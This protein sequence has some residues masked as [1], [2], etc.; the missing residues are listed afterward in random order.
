[1]VT[2][3][4]SKRSGTFK[5]GITGNVCSGKSVVRHALQR[6]GVNTMDAGESAMELLA[7]NPHKFALRLT[8]HFGSD[9]LDARGRLSRKKLTAV[10]LADPAKRELFHE[11]LNP[12]IRQEIKHFLYSQ[13][14]T[15]LRAVEASMLFETDTQHLYD[16]IWVV[17]AT[18]DKQLER[19]MNRDHVSHAHARLIVDSQWSQERK[20]TLGDRV[21]DNT[22]EIQHTETQVRK[23]LDEIKYKF[24]VGI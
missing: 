6:L 14:G 9:V 13:F 23:A 18:P 7:R 15:L 11:K 10:L 20:T 2:K 5:I 12:A 16:E 21:I 3:S 24:K 19:L 22:G 8:E 1:M 17:A 4:A